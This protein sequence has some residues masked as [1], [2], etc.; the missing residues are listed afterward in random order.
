MS[1]PNSIE[2]IDEFL[3]G[4]KENGEHKILWHLAVLQFFFGW[5]RMLKSLTIECVDPS[6]SNDKKGFMVN[7]HGIALARY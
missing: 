5:R 6:L 4:F 1:G 3:C 2:A 7:G